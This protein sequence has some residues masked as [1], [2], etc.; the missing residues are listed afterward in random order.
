MVTLLKEVTKSKDETIQAKDQM[1]NLLMR[2]NKT[3]SS[4][5][6]AAVE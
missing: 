2:N 5:G 1:I 3:C 6:V 4:C